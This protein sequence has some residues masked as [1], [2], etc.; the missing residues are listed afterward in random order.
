MTRKFYLLLCLIFILAL[1]LAACSSKPAVNSAAAAPQAN[2]PVTNKGV[3]AQPSNG[4]E[5]Q[6][7]WV[8][9]QPRLD[10]QGAVSVMITPLNQNNAYETIDFQ[11]AMNTHSV[12][13]SM[14]LA[15]LATLST[16][17]GYTVQAVLWEAPAGGH[18]CGPSFLLA[19]L[20]G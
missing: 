6:G 20:S 17:T 5:D 8:E 1:A 4:G 2:A 19:W 16:D 14:D 11:V 13:L 12:D 9:E 10:E 7:Y 15:A 18:C 3:S